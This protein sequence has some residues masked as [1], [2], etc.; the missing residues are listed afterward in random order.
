MNIPFKLILNVLI[1]R[2]NEKIC[3]VDTNGKITALSS[4]KTKVI[5]TSESGKEKALQ[6]YC[7]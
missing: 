3:I 4:G 1:N 2:K 7:K 6:V 5:C